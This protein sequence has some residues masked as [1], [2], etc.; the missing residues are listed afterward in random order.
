[1]RV[2]NLGIHVYTYVR[3]FRSKQMFNGKHVSQFATRERKRKEKKKCPYRV[4]FSVEDP[5]ILPKM[6]VSLPS[7]SSI[8]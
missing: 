3:E 5:L 2:K 6:L 1:M 4:R 8:V 7:P